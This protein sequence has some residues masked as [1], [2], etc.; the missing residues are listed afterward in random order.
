MIFLAGSLFVSFSFE[1][2][3]SEQRYDQKRFDSAMSRTINDESEDLGLIPQRL[4]NLHSCIGCG[5]LQTYDWWKS[6][7]CPNCEFPDWKPERCTSASF[8][9]MICIFQPSRSWCA[10]W[11]RFHRFRP[12][13]YAI[14]N[15]GEV[16]RALIEHLEK[17]KKP[18][19]E[20]VER[21]KRALEQQD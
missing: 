2:L 9:G 13:I 12:G 20:W 7:S 4:R 18:M 16:T 21:A 5:L 19:P 6:S 15:E 14:D 11:Q 10:K 1:D 3:M 8:S 17:H